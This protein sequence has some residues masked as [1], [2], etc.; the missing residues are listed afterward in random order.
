L[1]L[2]GVDELNVAEATAAVELEAGES[3][4]DYLAISFEELSDGRL[5]EFRRVVGDIQRAS[6][7]AL[8][9]YLVAVEIFPIADLR[10]RDI[11]RRFKFHCGHSCPVVRMWHNVD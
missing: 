9:V 5:V 8:D 7:A 1:C 10:G 2:L 11:F 3:Y 6:A 4:V